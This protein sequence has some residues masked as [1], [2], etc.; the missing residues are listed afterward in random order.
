MFSFVPVVGIILSAIP[1]VVMTL[2][3]SNGSL[4]LASWALAA[5]LLVHL[6][7]ATVLSPR[8]VGKMSI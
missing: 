8:I 5:V 7:E 3:Q 6:I 1:I 4:G 2:V